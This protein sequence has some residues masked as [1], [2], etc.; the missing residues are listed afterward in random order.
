MSAELKEIDHTIKSLQMQKAKL[1]KEC[2]HLYVS[3]VENIYRWDLDHYKKKFACLAHC[4]DCEENFEI[5]FQTLSEF[6]RLRKDL[7][8][9]TEVEYEFFDLVSQRFLDSFN[10]KNYCASLLRDLNK[11]KNSEEL[12]QLFKISN[13]QSSYPGSFNYLL[14]NW[15][16]P[17]S[18]ENYKLL[19]KVY[20]KLKAP[21]IK[22]DRATSLYLQENY[23]LFAKI[24]LGY[25]VYAVNAIKRLQNSN[26]IYLKRILNK[27]QK[28]S[29]LIESGIKKYNENN[30][31]KADCLIIEDDEFKKLG[32]EGMKSFKAITNNVNY[33]SAKH[34]SY[35]HLSKPPLKLVGTF[36]GL[37]VFVANY[38][39]QVQY[40]MILNEEDLQLSA[41][42]PFPRPTIF[43]I[44]EDNVVYGHGYEVMIE[45]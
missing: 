37:K 36:R 42:K 13:S 14:L 44:G 8:D 17:P 34:N 41:D 2:K 28:F 45:E 26:H 35:D 15:V 16:I 4:K 22:N 38:L 43:L 5:K 40:T 25:K 19:F 3:N 11:V 9:F 7:T 1:K 29:S 32:V 10:T 27:P 18:E 20:P 6:K 31:I 12:Q 30:K 23:D 39:S 33:I 24:F 21:E